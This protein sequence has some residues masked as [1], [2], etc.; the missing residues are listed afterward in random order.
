MGFCE[1]IEYL[2]RVHGS[3]ESDFKDNISLQYSC[4]FSI[5]Q[6]GEHVKRLSQELKDKYPEINWKGVAGL[7]DK[8]AHQYGTIDVSWVRSSALN[9]I[10]VL[11]NVCRKILGC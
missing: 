4:V 3:G 10:P 7:R 1:D 11:K 8:I 6:I 2:I 9:E 5:T